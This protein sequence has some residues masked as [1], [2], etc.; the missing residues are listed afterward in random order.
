MIGQ[1]RARGFMANVSRNLRNC[2]LKWSNPAGYLATVV[3]LPIEV[4]HEY[5]EKAFYLYHADIR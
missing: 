1:P 5:R 4:K 3:K 2:S